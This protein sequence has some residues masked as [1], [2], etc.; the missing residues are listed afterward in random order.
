M[1]SLKM[2]NV[3]LKIGVDTAEQETRKDPEKVDYSNGPRW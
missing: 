2:L 1:Y 3:L